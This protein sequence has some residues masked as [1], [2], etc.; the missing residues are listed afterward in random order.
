MALNFGLM[1]VFAF[2]LIATALMQCC[3]AACAEPG[4]ILAVFGYILIFS[5]SLADVPMLVEQISR[6]RDICRRL[7]G[8]KAG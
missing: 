1:E 8:A 4:Q 6:L 2:G 7:A 3:S 5:R